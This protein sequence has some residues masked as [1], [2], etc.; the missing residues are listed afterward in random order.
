MAI[1]QIKMDQSIKGHFQKVKG[2]TETT[3]ILKIT[4]PETLAADSLCNA[5]QVVT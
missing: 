1:R 4:V 3:F 5:K 2:K